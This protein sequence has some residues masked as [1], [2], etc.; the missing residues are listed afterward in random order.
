MKVALL[1]HH[2]QP[3]GNLEDGVLRA[4]DGA[5]RPILELLEAHPQ[6]RVNLHYSGAILEWLEAHDPALLERVRGLGQRSEQ[7]C[8]AIQEPLLALIPREDAVAQVGAHWTMLE[9]LFGVSARGF[10]LT[11]FAWEPH[12]PAL[13]ASTGLEWLPLPVTQFAP[14]TSSGVYTTEEQ[15]KSVKLI[16]A[17]RPNLERAAVESLGRRS[18]PKSDDFTCIALN[19]EDL[20]GR[21]AWLCDLLIALGAHQTVLLSNYIDATPAERLVYLPSASAPHGGSWR[22]ALMAHPE[23]DHLHKRAA[24]ASG[25]LNAVFRVPEEAHQH[26]WRAQSALPYW[27]A[28]VQLNYLRFNAYR[29]LINAEN[30]L[31]PRKYAWLE[32]AYRDLNL[33]G[34]DDVIVE[35][36]TMNLFFNPRLGGNLTEFDYRPAAVNL[37]DSF[38]PPGSAYPRRALIDHFL[39]AED[40]TLGDFASGDYLELGDFTSGAFEASK[41][42]DRVTLIRTGV[43]RGPNGVPVRMEVKKAVRLKHREGKLEIEYRIHN[44]GD[45]DVVTRF[46][47]EWNFGLLS[48]I[49][50]DRY[51]VIGGKRAGNLSAQ[52]EHRDATQVSIVDEWLGVRIDFEFPRETLLWTHPVYSQQAGVKHYQSSAVLPLWDLDVPKGRSRRIA[53]SVQVSDL[54]RERK[55]QNG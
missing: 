1:I 38:T 51:Y 24:Y 55:F 4:V 25:K 22:D 43:V 6:V 27:S 2:H 54:V 47:S 45:W 40:T 42:R 41:Y 30:I 12:L 21:T 15:G 53:Y 37:L 5:Y 52:R 13:I 32:I 29:N 11:E 3:S 46:G 31:E 50:E 17:V 34:S 26:L 20:I 28:G 16:A 10:Y 9:R 23:S 36:H 49:S 8:G 14:G 35:A 39:G 33:D 7:L 44:H 19:A 48:G 18:D